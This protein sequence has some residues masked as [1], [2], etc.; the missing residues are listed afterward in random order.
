YI[1]KFS[2]GCQV[3]ENAED[4]AEFMKLAQ[5]HSKLY[6]NSFTYTLI[7]LRAVQREGRRRLA[8]GAGLV[9]GVAGYFFEDIRE[10]FTN[11][12]KTQNYAT[13]RM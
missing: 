6:G 8:I 9:L 7:D 5:R 13:E 2:A 10:F 12:F 3:F 4:F 11:Q 1:E